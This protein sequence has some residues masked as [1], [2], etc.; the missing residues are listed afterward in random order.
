MNLRR[1]YFNSYFL[2]IFSI[3]GTARRDSLISDTRHDGSLKLGKLLFVIYFQPFFPSRCWSLVLLLISLK[4]QQRSGMEKERYCIHLPSLSK[5]EVI[6][7][8]H[9]YEFSICEHTNSKLAYTV[10]WL[11]VG[12]QPLMLPY[13]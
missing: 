13:S 9:S 8:R 3:A 7:A 10:S 2:P 6:L 4:L 5:I 11:T 1:S 12:C